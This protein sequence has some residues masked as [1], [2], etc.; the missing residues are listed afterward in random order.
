MDNVTE[1][2]APTGEVA[3][4]GYDPANGNRL[5]QRDGR[6]APSRVNLAYYA[7]GNGAGLVRLSRDRPGAKDSVAYDVRG[8]LVFSLTPLGYVTTS[9][10]DRLGRPRVATSPSSGRRAL[11]RHRT[12]SAVFP[13]VRSHWAPR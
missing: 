7:S 2:I 3:H 9:V 5:W 11:I 10:V 6:G 4:F 13:P 12:T 1:S 8:N